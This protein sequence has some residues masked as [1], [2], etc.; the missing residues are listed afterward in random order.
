MK[1]D[2]YAYIILLN[3]TILDPKLLEGR[4][5]SPVHASYNTPTKNKTLD[6]IKN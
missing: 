4:V 6:N 1:R 3:K 5:T 2:E